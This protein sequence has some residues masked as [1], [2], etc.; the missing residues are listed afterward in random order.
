MTQRRNV[1]ISGV[2]GFPHAVPWSFAI[3]PLIVGT[4]EILMAAGIVCG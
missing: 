3:P 1:S 2:F 4:G